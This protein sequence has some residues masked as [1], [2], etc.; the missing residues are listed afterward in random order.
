[1]KPLKSPGA[2][3][4]HALFFLSQ[5]SIVGPSLHRYVQQIWEGQPLDPGLN[6]TL[7]ALVPKSSAPTRISE[8]RPISLCSV[9]YK[10]LTKVIANR[11][12]GILPFIIGPFQSS[13]VQG[14]S[15]ID[16]ILIA[17]EVVHSM[18]KKQGK[19]GWFALKV[20]LEKAFDRL[21]WDFV[22]DTLSDID[23][24]PPMIN[25]IMQCISTAS[26]QVLWHGK[27]TPVFLP[28]RGIRQGDPLSPTSSSSAWSVCPT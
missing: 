1:M 20:D 8:F 15:I 27:A 10:I 3:G 16:N 28:H 23:L 22:H 19:G 26:M 12:R 25:V 24:P 18:Q 17:Q 14:R 21:R 2:D 5:W 4:L 13:F 7:I 6:R 11:L 9:P